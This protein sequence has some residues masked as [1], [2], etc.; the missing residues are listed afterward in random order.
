[1]MFDRTLKIETKFGIV[2]K[3]EGMRF[4]KKMNFLSCFEKWS[5]FEGTW[6]T[7]VFSHRFCVLNLIQFD[8]HARR[9]MAYIV[10]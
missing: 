8:C 2:L 7:D 9:K 1:M 10:G 4:F 5:N 6:P 3:V